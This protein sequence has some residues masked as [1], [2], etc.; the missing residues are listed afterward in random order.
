MEVE[1]P[2]NELL[3][4]AQAAQLRESG[5]GIDAF[6][7]T[8]DDKDI[9]ALKIAVSNLGSSFDITKSIAYVKWHKQTS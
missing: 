4:E 5:Y 2:A 3:G 7:A 6:V 1:K 8:L 9:A